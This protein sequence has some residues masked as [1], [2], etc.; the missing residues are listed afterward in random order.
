MPN[1]EE[2]KRRYAKFVA[3]TWADEEFR[4]NVMS[5]PA[6]ALRQFGF[7]IPEGK[8]VKIIEEDPEKIIHFVLPKKPADLLPGDLEEIVYDIIKAPPFPK[9]PRVFP[10]LPDPGFFWEGCLPPDELDP[11]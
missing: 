6:A 4:Q 9:L 7:N 2:A 3:K 10:C 11:I 8:E 5:D 1:E